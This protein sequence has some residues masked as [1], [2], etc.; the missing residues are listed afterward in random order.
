MVITAL[1]I[2]T[3]EELFSALGAA[4]N[5]NVAIAGRIGTLQSVQREDGSGKCFNVTLCR[6]DNSTMRFVYDK[7][8]VR[9][10]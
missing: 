8:F 10:K 4:G 6:Y 5:V 9:F 2:E 1:K 7:I 3:R